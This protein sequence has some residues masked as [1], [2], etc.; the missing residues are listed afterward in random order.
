MAR[1][2]YPGWGVDKD[3][4]RCTY[5]RLNLERNDI[6]NIHSEFWPGWPEYAKYS[7][8]P[9]VLQENRLF[10]SIFGTYYESY[11]GMKF[12]TLEEAQAYVDNILV[13]IGFKTIDASTECLI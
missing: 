10:F 13:H 8:S 6:V 7:W 4:S 12:D 9:G 2:L 11:R 1:L 3:Y 5:Y